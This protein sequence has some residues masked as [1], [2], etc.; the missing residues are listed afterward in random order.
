MTGAGER[1][2]LPAHAASVWLTSDALMVAFPSTSD[3]RGH[4]IAI[5]L[6]R[7][8]P[9]CDCCGGDLRLRA[10]TRGWPSL[11]GLLRERFHAAANP[12]HLRISHPGAPTQYS[13]DA[14]LRA[15]AA[16]RPP[17]ARTLAD[18][19]LQDDPSAT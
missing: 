16:S 17:A 11:L 2:P 9:A 5:P 15:V 19:G 14:I 4:T 7:L 8:T 13:I 10:T 1:Y 12:Q 18:L 6:S 3:A